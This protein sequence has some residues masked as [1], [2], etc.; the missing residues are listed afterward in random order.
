MKYKREILWLQYENVHSERIQ[1][2]SNM[3]GNFQVVN[4][5]TQSVVTQLSLCATQSSK[6]AIFCSDIKIGFH[7]STINHVTRLCNSM[8]L[9]FITLCHIL[10]IRSRDL[11][12]YN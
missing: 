12:L 11:D 10:Y 9:P 2:H 4:V 3:V 8:V 5:A 6:I 1:T 7:F